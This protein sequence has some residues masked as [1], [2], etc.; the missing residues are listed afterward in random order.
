[1]TAVMSYRG[2]DMAMVL[3]LLLMF[4]RTTVADNLGAYYNTYYNR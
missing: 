4:Q 2:L 3:L 1:M